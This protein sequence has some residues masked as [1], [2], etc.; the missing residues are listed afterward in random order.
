MKLIELMSTNPAKIY[1]LEG[2]EIAV[3]KLADLAIIDLESEYKIEKFKSKSSNS[4]F[5]GKNLRGEVL[6]TISEGK[7]VYKK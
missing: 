2:G 1:G 7:L 4:P 3:G 5:A 6:Y